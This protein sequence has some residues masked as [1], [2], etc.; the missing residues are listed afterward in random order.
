MRATAIKIITIFILLMSVTPPLFALEEGPPAPIEIP[1]HQKENIKVVYQINTAEIKHGVNKGLHYVSYIIDHYKRMGVPAKNIKLIAVLYG[2]ASTSLLRERAY[3]KH[4]G[5]G[6]SNPNKALIEELNAQGVQI[7]LCGESAR[8][9][10]IS[11]KE[12][13]P[14]VKVNVGAYARVID[15]QHQ[16]Y[17]YIKFL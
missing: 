17:A 1:L 15:L 16:G 10:N 9:R 14:A 3:K 12:I 13:L 11:R 7:E 5:R 6:E 4:G 2:D 8:L